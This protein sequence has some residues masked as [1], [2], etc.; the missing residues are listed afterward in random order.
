MN[1]SNLG[2]LICAG[3]LALGLH[4]FVPDSAQTPSSEL[5]AVDAPVK[6]ARATA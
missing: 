6:P 4:A 1:I 5:P 2:R 3:L